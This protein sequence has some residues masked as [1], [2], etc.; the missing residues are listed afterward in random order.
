MNYFGISEY[1]KPI[2]ENRPLAETALA[3]VLLQ[4]VA[5]GKNQS[6]RTA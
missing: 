3:H 1:Y 4:I 2:P 6:A 5:M